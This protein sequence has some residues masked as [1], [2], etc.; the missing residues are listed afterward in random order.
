MNKEDYEEYVFGEPGV[1]KQSL[2]ILAN[3]T[4]LSLI[5]S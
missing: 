2:G 1:P 4:T 5:E 3:K